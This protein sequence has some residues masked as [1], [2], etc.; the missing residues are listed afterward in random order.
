MKTEIL[1]SVFERVESRKDSLK[2]LGCFNNI[3]IEGWFKV[4]VIAA[5][6]GKVKK[7]QNKGPDLLMQDRTEIELKAAT[8][9]NTNYIFSGAS[10]YN[11]PCLFLGDRNNI[12]QIQKLKSNN[13]FQ[14]EYKAFNDGNGDWIVGIAEI[15]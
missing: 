1:N 8:D 6:N 3:G 10:K 4:E 7:I 13:K 9:L 12:N 14:V 11:V 2:N 15:T 5:L